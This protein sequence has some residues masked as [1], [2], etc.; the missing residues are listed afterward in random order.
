MV[1][2]SIISGV[3]SALAAHV[4]KAIGPKSGSDGAPSRKPTFTASPTDPSSPHDILPQQTAIHCRG[5]HLVDGFPVDLPPSLSALLP[6]SQY[7]M[8]L[9]ELQEAARGH[10]DPREA[11][12]LAQAAVITWNAKFFGPRGLSASLFSTDDQPRSPDGSGSNWIEDASTAYGG[13]RQHREYDRRGREISTRHQTMRAVNDQIYT[14]IYKALGPKNKQ[15]KSAPEITLVI[16]LLP[17]P[18]T[19]P[20]GQFQAP[21][22]SQFP[23]QPAPISVHQMQMGEQHPSRGSSGS[24]GK[25]KPLQPSQPSQAQPESDPDA[26]PPPYTDDFSNATVDASSSSSPTPATE[27]PLQDSKDEKIGW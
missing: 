9:D 11:W 10:H 4:V 12:K 1:V 25:G 26:P 19:M 17:G 5:E 24:G 20:Y 2:G 22:G 27:R 18:K 16:S 23:L 8:F 21:Y 15:P 3:T 7:S 13:Q 14:G 6:P